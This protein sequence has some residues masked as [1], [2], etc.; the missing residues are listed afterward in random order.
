MSLYKFVVKKTFGPTSG[1][2]PFVNDYVINS[3]LEIGTAGIVT[4][5]QA[6]ADYEKAFYQREVNF[7]SVSVTQIEGP[8]KGTPQANRVIPI[9]GTGSRQRADVN[10]E[11]GVFSKPVVLYVKAAAEAGSNGAKAYRGVL[12]EENVTWA[13]G[14]ATIAPFLYDYF[15][16]AAA[17]LFAALGNN[18]YVIQNT[19]D[20]VGL[21]WSPVTS[22]TIVGVK[23]HKDT[24]K[25]KKNREEDTPDG[26]L[27]WLQDNALEL[28]L[29]AGALIVT[30]GKVGKEAIA[31]RAPAMGAAASTMKQTIEEIEDILRKATQV[32]P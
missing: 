29:A 26:V 22:L 28:A 32:Q 8:L 30:R 12:T 11:T 31:A 27:G 9:G 15:N 21:G 7:L 13:K 18:E 5:A 16:A 19:K 17:A 23:F 4:I 20:G 1:K 10:A 6:L 24:R 2:G 3:E 25:R 14:E